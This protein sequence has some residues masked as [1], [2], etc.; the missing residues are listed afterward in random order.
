[1]TPIQYEIVAGQHNI[2]LPDIHEEVKGVQKS[3]IIIISNSPFQSKQ[4]ALIHKKYNV[5]I[6]L[7]NVF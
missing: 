1:M 6:H 2:H 4:K 3:S 7:Q 5:A